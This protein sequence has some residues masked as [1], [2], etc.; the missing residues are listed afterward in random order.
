[1]R[2]VTLAGRLLATRGREQ[3]DASDRRHGMVPPIGGTVSAGQWPGTISGGWGL[4]PGFAGRGGVPS[5]LINDPD[6]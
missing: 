1:M 6:K 3:G 5:I 4:P 2:G